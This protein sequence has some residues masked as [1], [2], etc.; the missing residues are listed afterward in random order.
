MDKVRQGALRKMIYGALLGSLM[1]ISCAPAVGLANSHAAV[2]KTSP[3]AGIPRTVAQPPLFLLEPKRNVTTQLRIGVFGTVGA[4]YWAS[5]KRILLVPTAGLVTEIRMTREAYKNA[6]EESYGGKL[7][8]VLTIP[9][10]IPIPGQYRVVVEQSDLDAPPGCEISF[11][12][13]LGTIHR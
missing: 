3:C 7:A 9:A 2:A 5:M 10:T 4:D 8:S 12:I 6:H 11:F 1:W 13:A